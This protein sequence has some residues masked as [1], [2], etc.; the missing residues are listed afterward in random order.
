MSERYVIKIIAQADGSPSP[1]DGQYLAE[2]DP[3]GFD[4]RGY[5][6]AVSDPRYAMIFHG[7]AAAFAYWKTQSTDKP[8]RED[9][10]PNRPLTAYTVEFVK[11]GGTH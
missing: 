4:G 5:A 7:N 11:I 10:Q 8:F 1:V 6:R 2:F 3:D 9:G